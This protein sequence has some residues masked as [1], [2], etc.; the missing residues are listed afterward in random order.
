MSAD[1]SQ[2]GVLRFLL[3]KGGR[4]SNAELMERYGSFL[5]D[6]HDKSTA[7]QAFKGFVNT[8]GFVNTEDGVKYIFLK[9]KFRH[10]LQD[11]GAS[12]ERAT[13]VQDSR[14]DVRLSTPA[15]Q[16]QTE[17]EGEPVTETAVGSPVS[18]VPHRVQWDTNN[19]FGG[20]LADS[21]GL[22]HCPTGQSGTTTIEDDVSGIQSQ[23]KSTL[24]TGA[25]NGRGLGPGGRQDLSK[26]D[27]S[28][29]SQDNEVGADPSTFGPSTSVPSAVSTLSDYPG[30]D[31]QCTSELRDVL[32]LKKSNGESERRDNFAKEIDKNVSSN[33]VGNLT[34]SDVDRTSVTQSSDDDVSSNHSGPRLALDP[35]EHEWTIRAAEGNWEAVRAMLLRDP[36]LALRR[37]P[38]TGLTA[39]HWAAKHGSADIIPLLLAAAEKADQRHEDDGVNTRS[40]GGYTPL[41]LAAMHES[42]DVA[43][44]LVG[45]YEANVKARDY[46][47][48]RPWQYLRP[49]A[50]WDIKDLLGAPEIEDDEDDE[51]WLDNPRR[52]PQSWRSRLGKAQLAGFRLHSQSADSGSDDEVDAGGGGGRSGA[53]SRHDHL[54]SLVNHKASFVKF[55]RPQINKH[56]TKS[57]RMPSATTMSTEE[58][59]AQEPHE[60]C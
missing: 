10:L 27:S 4:C 34:K 54:Q 29:T 55:F 14:E 13:D 12:Q 45:A 6:P 1:F 22:V 50:G 43:K 16:T 19:S 44:M 48:L 40:A 21:G 49:T 41:H 51:V 59:E 11:H 3:E 15:L 24:E 56:G 2:E 39:L 28:K 47:G 60:S 8:L 17:T 23:I 26:R 38:L 46:G 25:G 33:A 36:G 32:S 30:Q 18:N 58:Q 20:I 5:N 35:T 7:R 53:G 37:D 9:K 52:R 31:D 42:L 57:Q